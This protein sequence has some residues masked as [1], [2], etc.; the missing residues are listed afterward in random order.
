METGGHWCVARASLL[1]V[2]LF[3][4]SILRPCQTDSHGPQGVEC[5]GDPV[6]WMGES[7]AKASSSLR[8]VASGEE[9]SHEDR[10]RDSS[11][12][13]AAQVT[14]ESGQSQK[15]KPHCQHWARKKFKKR[16]GV[17]RRSASQC[18]PTQTSSR[19]KQSPRWSDSRELW[20][21]WETRWTRGRS[22]QVSM[23]DRVC[24]IHRL[25]EESLWAESGIRVHEGKTQLWNA[26]GES[27]P[28]HE[29][30]QR[31][32]VLADPAPVVWWGSEDLP[33]HR[34]GIKVLGTPLGHQ[35]FVRA[36]LE[37]L[38]AH[39]HTLL[40]RI[41][42]VEDVS[43]RGCFWFTAH[44]LGRTMWLEVVEPQMAAA[45]CQRHD[46]GV[47]ECLPHISRAR[48]RRGRNCFHA[49]CFGRHWIA[50]CLSWEHP[51]V[52][53]ELGRRVEGNWSLSW[54]TSLKHVSFRPQRWRVVSSL[55]SCYLTLP[56]GKQQLRGHDHHSGNPTT[57]S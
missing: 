38:S 24:D 23:L 13:V 30:L 51:S 57:S 35:D 31:A 48:G 10:S 26:I 25:L 21:R 40:A 37:M 47:W 45:F 53:G 49:F 22:D 20:T 27:P 42:M 5:D 28:G 7:F 54:S 33:S 44:L 32:A 41:P 56:V 43:R 11:W 12:S 15:S 8:A 6:R 29:R 52:L 9:E 14:G 4:V 2:T 19:Q 34:R 55:V 36:Q 39:H 18:V 50:I 16:C 3:V 17:P 46:A 1:K